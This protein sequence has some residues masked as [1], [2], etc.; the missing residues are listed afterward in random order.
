MDAQGLRDAYVN[1]FKER[2][3]TYIR[4]ASLIPE[5][6]P[7]VL[8]TTAGMHPLVPYLL[9]EK[10]PGGKRLVN[11]QKCIRTGDIEEVGDDSHLT[12]FEM[13]GNWSLGDY[14]KKESIRFSYDL[15]KDV[16]NIKRDQLAVT[17]FEGEEGIPK[18]T[19]TA[20]H[21]KDLGFRDDQIF[22]YGRKDNWWGP[23][24]QTG[25]CG[26][27]TEIFFDNGKKK[28]GP[29]CGP[30]C[31]CGKYT[32]IWNNV[33]MQYNKDKDGKF[34]PLA[35][36]NVDTGMGLERTLCFVNG[37]KNV[38]ETSLFTGIIGKLEELSGKKYSDDI[39][40]FRIVADHLRASTFLLGD[41]VVPSKMGQGYILRRLIRRASRYMSK[42][43]IEGV[44]MQKISEVIVS[45]YSAAYPELENNKD[46]I[47]AQITAEEEKFHR[48]LN[49][50]LRRFDEMISES[51]EKKELD[52]ESV[53]RL[54][55]TYGFPIELTQE[56]A[57]EKGFTVCIADFENRFK[58][59][60]EK[61]RAG[62]DQVFKGG[63][64]DA[65]EQTTRLHTATHLLNAALKRFVDPNIH[66]KGSNITAER[67]RF[68]F[69][70]D[71]KVEPEELKKIE[72]FVNEV[73]NANIPVV[74]EEIPYEEAQKRHAEGVF[75]CKYGEIVKVY[76]IGDVSVEL[77]GGPH[78]KNTGEIGSFKI[79]KEESSAAGV[80][81]IKAVVE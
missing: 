33:F 8:F 29:K 69:N 40:S 50:G 51:G 43:G 6:D 74:C 65:S 72:D 77:C 39:R 27:D 16:L 20:R 24:G 12:F 2:G 56:L 66:Q 18:D 68:D 60:Q 75:Q 34:V 46:S 30:A 3:H 14:F 78:V 36:K 59:H 28:C 44:N 32:E 48:T 7:T 4:S 35:Q 71:R 67:L 13:L 11:F 26:P 54:Y 37:L 57:A 19:E 22:F 63:L 64:A 55:D 1:F 42:L 25:P 52:G 41:G 9:G 80:R 49:K 70:L 61:S 10:H 17:A 45:E 47:Y 23:A 58:E 15:L 79:M 38:Y 5:N 21:W 81:R 73:I 62:S 53:F 76:S 31:K